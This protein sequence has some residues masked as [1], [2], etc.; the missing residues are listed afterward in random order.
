MSFT[1]AELADIEARAS[2]QNNAQLVV[3]RDKINQ[4]KVLVG[5]IHAARAELLNLFFPRYAPFVDQL[6][7]FTINVESLA[8]NSVLPLIN[9]IVGSQE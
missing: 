2:T 3:I 1:Q 7:N 5:E 4:I 6:N 8:D 9:N